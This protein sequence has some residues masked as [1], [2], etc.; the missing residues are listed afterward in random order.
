MLSLDDP[1]SSLSL[2]NIPSFEL[3]YFK[4]QGTLYWH[5]QNIIYTIN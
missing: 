1:A 3:T 5:A 2:D 4:F